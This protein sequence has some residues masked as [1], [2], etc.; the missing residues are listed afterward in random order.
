MNID[1]SK[2][3][4]SKVKGAIE[5]LQKGDAK[6]WFTFFAQEVI[7]YDDGNQMQFNNFFRK[8]LGKE[9]FIKIDKVEN[10]GLAIYGDFHSDQWGVFKT[11]FKF[12]INKE[13]KISRLEIEQLS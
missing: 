1:L 3:K 8:A 2:L 7:F 6:A 10:N 12:Q 13:G 11:I 4:N 5:A 9:R